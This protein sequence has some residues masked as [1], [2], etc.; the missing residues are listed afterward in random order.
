MDAFARRFSTLLLIALLLTPVALH[1]QRLVIEAESYIA[2]NEIGGDEIQAIGLS[3]CSGGYY[4]AGLDTPGEWVEYDA[5]VNTAGVYSFG[6]KCRGALDREYKFR[7]VFTPLLGGATRSV[8]FT[9]RG[10]GFG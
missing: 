1:A 7:A 10:E 4:L 3:G 2:S 6:L 8:D 9:F 5:A